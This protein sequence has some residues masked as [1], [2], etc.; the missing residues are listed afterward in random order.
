MVGTSNSRPK[1]VSKN[2][3]TPKVFKLGFAKRDF[4]QLKSKEILKYAN[5]PDGWSKRKNC[6]FRKSKSSPD[7]VFHLLSNQELTSKFPS[8]DGFSATHFDPTKSVPR[9]YLNLDNYKT[10]PSKYT[11]TKTEYRAY[12]VQHELGH[13][14]FGKQHDEET[15]SDPK[16]GECSVM[17]QQTLGTQ[18]CKPGHSYVK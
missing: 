17:F 18:E 9:I 1:L 13:A 10:P 14:L 7:V 4:I 15:D 6:R 5:L 2:S 3:K 16:T 11:G 8:M 12:V